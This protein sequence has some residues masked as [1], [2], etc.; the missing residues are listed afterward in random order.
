MVYFT[1]N[2]EL[3]IVNWQLLTIKNSFSLSQTH[4]LSHRGNRFRTGVRL[5]SDRLR[6]TSTLGLYS[7]LSV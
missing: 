3:R 4:H 7:S 1:F 6:L 5:K 2:C